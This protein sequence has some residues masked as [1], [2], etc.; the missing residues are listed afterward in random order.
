MC[1]IAGLVRMGSI[2]ACESDERTALLMADA[3]AHRGPDDTG[4]WAD[5][6]GVV[7]GHKRLAILDLSVA[8][9]Q[10]MSSRSSRYVIVFNGEIYNHLELR[11]A[12][13]TVT[14]SYIWRGQSDTETILECFEAWGVERTL[15]QMVGMFAIALWDKRD[16]TLTL[17]RDRFGEKPLYYG[18]NNNNFLFGSELKALTVHPEWS[19]EIDREALSLY[20]RYGY[21]PTPYSIWRGI[22]KLPPGSYVV[23]AG[24]TTGRPVLCDPIAY[25]SAR[26]FSDQGGVKNQ[27]DALATDELD[28]LL[29]Q[30]VKGQML[31]D[32]PVGAFLSG[33]IDS[34]TVVAV[35]QSEALRPV[36]TFT[37][38]FTE[39]DYDESRYAKAVAQHLKTDHIEMHVSPADAQGLI[40]RLPTMYDEPF[41]DVSQLPTH[42][43]S[44]LAKQRVSVSLSGDGGDE[45]FG[46]Y[47]RHVLGSQL[48]SR[49]QKVPLGIRQ[50]L[51]NLVIKISPTGWDKLGGYLPNSLRQPM[52]GDKV[53]KLAGLCAAAAPEDIYKWLVSH[54]REPE[55]L[56]L[57]S[58]GH[59]KVL[60]TWAQTE[61]EQFQQTSVNERM[62]FND[63][64]GYL[65]DDILCKVDRAAMAV[66]LETRVPLLDHRIAE[67]A[68]SLPLHMKIRSGQGKWLLRQVLNRYV[69]QELID[70]P[71]QGFGVPLDSWLRGPLRKWA[72]SLLEPSRLRKEGYLNAELVTEKWREHISEQRNWQN[73][74]WNV[75]M[76]Q[77]WH[78]KWVNGVK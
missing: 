45:L 56:L 30:S 18:W 24:A 17:M 32:V 72:E 48:W 31:S 36:Q 78:E 77:A 39:R 25:W 38:G 53:H 3:L 6:T 66:S 41:S 58:E 26:T 11:N 49:M 20:L 55:R 8:G 64:V 65:T 27:T 19:A 14:G 33:G 42:L 62:M 61:A 54:E 73:W 70:R 4:V 10:P 5:G 69:P 29:H 51:G 74:L 43:V 46:G 16:R 76:F 57:G 23:L 21:V 40:S 12:L 68:F 44:V 34:S 15:K 9:H 2:R 28:R 52:L 22:K 13:A 35:M 50:L 1:G 59:S 71:K 60:T 37:I 47:N 75:L 7:L 63:V 67:F